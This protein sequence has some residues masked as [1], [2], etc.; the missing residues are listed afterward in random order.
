MEQNPAGTVARQNQEPPGDHTL[1]EQRDNQ[2][3][4][5]EASNAAS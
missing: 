1:E 3:D 2:D 4:V 5:V